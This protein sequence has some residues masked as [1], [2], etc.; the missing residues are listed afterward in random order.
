MTAFVNVVLRVAVTAGGHCDTVGFYLG[1]IGGGGGDRSVQ[2]G[3]AEDAVQEV[4]V[5]TWVTRF[6]NTRYG[7]SL[8]TAARTRRGR[9]RPP[10]HRAGPGWP[11]AAR[12]SLGCRTGGRGALRDRPI[13][14]GQPFTQPLPDHHRQP[15]VGPPGPYMAA[16]AA[17]T[18][19][20]GSRIRLWPQD[21]LHARDIP[22]SAAGMRGQQRPPTR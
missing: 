8:P 10:A 11:G 20:S 3:L 18:C 13:L 16:I 22:D 17:A 1:D 5:A 9:R 2:Y 15:L 19:G 6:G 21:R 4:V 12:T 7:Q 14:I